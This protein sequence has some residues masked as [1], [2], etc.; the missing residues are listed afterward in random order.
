M[1]T[2][3]SIELPEHVKSKI[4]HEVENLQKKNLIKGKF[5]EKDN[6]HLTLKFLGNISEEELKKIKKVLNEISFSKFDCFVGKTGIFD[7]ENHIKIIWVNLISKKLEDLQKEISKKFPEISLNYKE[8][9]S[10]ITLARVNSVINK[11]KLLDTI[12]NLHFKKLDFTVNEI[13]LMKTELMRDG[14]KYRVLE[15]F[16][17]E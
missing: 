1:R 10:H 7:D 8:F 3:I 11:E 13:A 2:F 5:V 9:K 16:P 4:F 12:N 6:L 15:K 17:L 14:K